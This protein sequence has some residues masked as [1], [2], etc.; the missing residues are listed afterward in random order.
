VGLCQEL[1]YLIGWNCEGDARR[2]L[3]GVN[4]N[5]LA[6]LKKQGTQL[7]NS[8]RVRGWHRLEEGRKI[9]RTGDLEMCCQVW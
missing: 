7:T 3:Q 9:Y 2:H 8:R 5:H 4:P 1:F 6:I